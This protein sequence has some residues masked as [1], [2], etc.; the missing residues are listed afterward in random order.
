VSNIVCSDIIIDDDSSDKCG[1]ECFYYE[2]NNICVDE[3]PKFYYSDYDNY[4]CIEIDCMERKPDMNLER[5]VCGEDCYAVDNYTCV[6]QCPEFY[7]PNNRS[8]FC[9]LI[10]CN[11]R[12]P[13]RD[14]EESNCGDDCFFDPRK[15]VCVSEC[16]V[17][18]VTS[19]ELAGV[20][21]LLDCESRVPVVNSESLSLLICGDFPCFFSENKC[22]LECPDNEKHDSNGICVKEEKSSE[23][24]IM[25][26]FFIILIIISSII[27]LILI[28]LF[29]SFSFLFLFFSFS[30]SFLF[31]LFFFFF[32]FL[33]FSLQLFWD[34]HRRRRSSNSRRL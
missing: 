7:K 29:F 10:R 27:L 31:L 26:K 25:N 21:I 16:D 11:L 18:Y 24:A 17:F 1:P 33:F 3:C 9:E 6:N 28:A 8:S 20:C 34:D 4:V 32:L 19:P 30:F 13:I 14:K 5:N 22:V 23:D 12:R 2:E 15:D